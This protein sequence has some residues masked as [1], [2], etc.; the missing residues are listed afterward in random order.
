MGTRFDWDDLQAFLAVARAGRL[1]AGARRLGVDHSTLSRRIAALEEAL[2][3]PLFHRDPMGYTP[4]EHGERLLETAEAMESLALGIQGELT[5]MRQSVTGAVRVGAPDGFGTRFLAPRMAELG[6][7]HA[8][9]EVQLVA[10]P[11][12]FS[13]S[14]READIAIGLSQPTQG[15]LHA[16]KLTD[17]ELG[18]YAAPA[19]LD[20]QPA[21]TGMEQ[22][23]AHRF[24]AYIDDLIF[25]PELD[26]LPHVSRDIRP[27]LKSTS[28]VAQLEAVRAGAGIGVLPCFLAAPDPGLVR[29]LPDEVRLT[30]A[31]WLLVHSDLRRLAR[32]RAVAD[33]IAEEVAAAAALFSP[34]A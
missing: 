26:Y 34:S 32:V 29:V 19:Y 22:L 4:T 1:T 25:T 27:F 17:Y 7:R 13:L 21:I 10:M 23:T 18:L 11:R 2:G 9:L 3:A 15:R 30:R 28:I 12:I 24:V 14:K 31:F 6:R 8:G 16:R 5:G 20:G 33:F